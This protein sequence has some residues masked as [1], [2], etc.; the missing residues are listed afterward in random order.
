MVLWVWINL[1]HVQA[2]VHGA[3]KRH[4]WATNGH[5]IYIYQKKKNHSDSNQ[6]EMFTSHRILDFSEPPFFPLSVLLLPYDCMWHWNA[7]WVRAK[8]KGE[9]SSL[10]K[11][12]E[13]PFLL[14]FSRSSVNSNCHFWILGYPGPR[15]RHRRLWH[16]SLPVRQHFK[17]RFYSLTHLYYLLWSLKQLFYV[18]CPSFTMSFNRSNGGEW[19]CSILSRTRTLPA[20]FF[21]NGIKVT[22]LLTSNATL[23]SMNHGRNEIPG[24]MPP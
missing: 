13:I 12:W 11:Y 20:L 24:H 23:N 5:A 15:S 19:S 22:L 2:T 14:L 1:W 4:D 16:N 9:I 21:L 10:P 6:R 7:C 17:F 3:A 18:F 8:K